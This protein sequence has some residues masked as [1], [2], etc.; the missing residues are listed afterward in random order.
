MNEK[1]S[2]EK[3]DLIND[4]KHEYGV[5]IGIVGQNYGIG[6]LDFLRK[7]YKNQHAYVTGQFLNEFFN[8]RLLIVLFE[9][10]IK[11]WDIKYLEKVLL[12]EIG[13][14]ISYRLTREG[15][16]ELFAYQNFSGTKQE[17]MENAGKSFVSQKTRNKYSDFGKNFFK[18]NG[19]KDD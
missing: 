16:A 19:K 10:N 7:L 4:L 12:H 11:Q 3:I 2:K 8:K 15:R 14:V 5:K 6:I 9:E 17:F 13:H 18:L 1:I